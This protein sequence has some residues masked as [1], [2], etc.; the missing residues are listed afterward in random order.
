MRVSWRL[1]MYILI[2]L[3]ILISLFGW[4]ILKGVEEEVEA[5]LVREVE[6]I[7]RALQT[8]MR[9][10]ILEGD[11]SAIQETLDSVFTI[12]S[13]YG[14]FVYDHRGKLLASAGRGGNDPR[15]RD[16]IVDLLEGTDNTGQYVNFD[17]TMV[18][19]AFIPVTDILEGPIG[20]IQINRDRS[21]IR[22]SMGSVRLQGVFL[23]LGMIFLSAMVVMVGHYVAQ[24]KAVT[25]LLRSIRRIEK[26][27]RAHRARVTGPKETASIAHAL[28]RMMTSLE[29]AEEELMESK[30]VERLL[31]E[32]VTRNDRLLSLGKLAGGVAHELG[33]PLSV[34]R[35]QIRRLRRLEEPENPHVAK[36]HT[37]LDRLEKEVLRTEDVVGQLLD[38]GSRQRRFEQSDVA[39]VVEAGVEASTPELERHHCRAE[40]DLGEEQPLPTVQMDRLRLTMALRNLLSNAARHGPNELVRIIVRVLPAKISFIVQDFGEGIR[41][42]EEDRIFEPFVSGSGNGH[43][44]GLAL[45][46]QVAREHQGIV[47]ARNWEQGAEFRL[48]LP[49]QQ[50]NPSTPS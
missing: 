44:L 38:F 26:G 1:V 37:C 11:D 23:S 28:N 21:E 14:A 9:R 5:N 17:D 49:L 32:Q 43:G 16:Y 40:V 10:A 24:G 42:G 33:A 3:G 39:K 2:P 12:G 29:S 48:I 50:S 18:Y 6:V 22:S 35:G 45:V 15:Y 47:R 7:G 8:P 20:L 13:V 25:R 31:R 27:D 41:P 19:S 4:R 30:A 46:Q 36:R 34:I